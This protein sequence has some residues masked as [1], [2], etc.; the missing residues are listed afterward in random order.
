MKKFAKLLLVSTLVVACMCMFTACS[1]SDSN[2]QNNVESSDMANG[3]DQT[4]TPTNSPEPTMTPAPTDNAT[5][6]MTPNDAGNGGI[7]DDV[8]NGAEDVVDGVTQ[9]V[10]DTVNGVTDGVDNA[11]QPNTQSTDQPR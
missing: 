5:T 10:E 4:P 7:I 8:M 11:T 3:V 9:G 6:T 1:R 2:D